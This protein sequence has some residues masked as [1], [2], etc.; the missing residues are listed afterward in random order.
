ME[1]GITNAVTEVDDELII[2]ALT[3]LTVT[4]EGVVKSVPEMERRVPIV[5]LL[6]EKFSA[7]V[8]VTGAEAEPEPEPEPEPL[9]VAP[10][11]TDLLHAATTAKPKI[12]EAISTA[13]SLCTL[14]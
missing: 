2:R 5:P 7:E 14:I 10:C 12:L 1:P 11:L 9:V 4:A 8:G 13:L 3:P 6:G